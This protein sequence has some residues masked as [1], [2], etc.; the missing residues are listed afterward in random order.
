MVR[1]GVVLVGRMM[2][3]LVVGVVVVGGKTGDLVGVVGERGL[4]SG[5]KEMGLTWSR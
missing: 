4:V 3:R 5:S 2:G 1:V